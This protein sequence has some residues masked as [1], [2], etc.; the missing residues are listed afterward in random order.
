MKNYTELVRQM[1]IQQ[2]HV[3]RVLL[4]PAWLIK[5][6][7]ERRAAKRNYVPYDGLYV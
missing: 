1:E 4:Y 5:K 7:A 3:L 6:E 2:F